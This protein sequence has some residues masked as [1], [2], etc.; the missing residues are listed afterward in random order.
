MGFFGVTMLVAGDVNPATLPAVRALGGEP[1]WATAGTGHWQLS[2]IH[3]ADCPDPDQVRAATEQAGA[4]FMCAYILDS[5]FAAVQCCRP[6]DEV[7]SFVLHATS[8]RGYDYPVSDAEQ[9]AAVGYLLDWA[10]A[11]ADEHEVRRAL[12][13]RMV[14]AED[15]VLRLAAALGALPMAN[16]S[17][18][19]FGDLTELG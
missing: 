5:D 4:A 13:G 17:D 3:G 6:G 16:L 10:G 18:Y 9:E 12:S 14:S 2:R 15:S 11:G 8:A 7:T 1:D 19:L